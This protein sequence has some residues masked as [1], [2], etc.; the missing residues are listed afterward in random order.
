MRL[1]RSFPH[2]TQTVTDPLAH[3]SDTA[4]RAIDLLS[5]IVTGTAA[6]AALVTL[7]DIALVMTIVA[8]FMSSAWYGM[9]FYDR[10]RYGRGSAE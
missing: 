10:I 2:G 1:R 6:G 4:K 8:A 9:R 5:P 3:I 7:S